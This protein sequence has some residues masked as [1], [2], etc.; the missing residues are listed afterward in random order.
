MLPDQ[1]PVALQLLP[2]GADQRSVTLFPVETELELAVRFR[3]P[4]P[5][6]PELEPEALDALPPA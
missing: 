2:L 4:D 6:V 3:S 5:E 1:S